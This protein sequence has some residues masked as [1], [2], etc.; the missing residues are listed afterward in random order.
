MQVIKFVHVLRWIENI[1]R[2]IEELHSMENN[3]Q[4]DRE[5]SEKV[6]IALELEIN[7]LLNEKVKLMELK[8]E[9]PP[10]KI[11]QM[12]YPEEHTS[13]VKTRQKEKF[14]LEEM[15][16]DYIYDFLYGKKDSG[17]GNE[18]SAESE[19]EISVSEKKRDDQNF[20][21]P[22]GRESVTRTGFRREEIQSTPKSR[23]QIIKE[24]PMID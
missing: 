16:K 6:R 17:N 3:L 24:L 13:V 23:D 2:D 22:A 4:D 18:K 10:E 12:I 9:N 15:E 5:Y 21:R 14:P 19:R 7:T 8:I 20:L 11:L 1:E